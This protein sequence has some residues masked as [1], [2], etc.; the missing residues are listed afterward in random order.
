MTYRERIMQDLADIINVANLFVSDWCC[1][2]NCK[3]LKGCHCEDCI[4]KWLDSEVD[5]AK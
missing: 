2:D 1:D 4:N 3:H 5:Y